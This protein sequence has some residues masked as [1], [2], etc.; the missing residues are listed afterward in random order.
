MV[1]VKIILVIRVAI[2]VI[3]AAMVFIVTLM[4]A[5]YGS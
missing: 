5:K 3:Q 1:I 2:M 4:I